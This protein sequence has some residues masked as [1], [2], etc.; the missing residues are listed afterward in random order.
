M[1]LDDLTRVYETRAVRAYGLEGVS[2]LEHALQSAHLARRAG[3][4][5]ALVVAC[6][7]HDVGNLVHDLG[8]NPAAEGVDDRHEAL[9][10]EWLATWFPAEVVD[11]VR[12]HVAA[13]RYLVAADPTYAGRL[14]ADSVLSLRL[15]GG[16]MD[17]VER[18]AFEAE[19]FWRDAITLRRFDEEAKIPGAETPSFR[20]FLPVIAACAR[21]A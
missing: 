4:S 11:P 14:S 17:A 7:L 16:P 5:D 12:L 20:D 13:K 1:T 18:A 10:A 6:L 2:Q 3:K 9:G 8:E 15:Q 21:C 19:P